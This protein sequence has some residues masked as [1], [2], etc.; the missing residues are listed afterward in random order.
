MDVTKIYETV[1]AWVKKLT[2]DVEHYKK[3][4]L[5]EVEQLK[6]EIATAKRAPEDLLIARDATAM[7]AGVGNVHIASDEPVRAV[8]NLG[9]SGNNEISLGDI[10]LPESKNVRGNRRVDRYRAIVLLFKESE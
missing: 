3:R 6:A 8:L 10:R 4:M 2:D 1:D 5:E 9:Y 7:L